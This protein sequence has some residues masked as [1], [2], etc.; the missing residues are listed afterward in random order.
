MNV[1]DC[2]YMSKE[3]LIE[4]MVSWGMLEDNREEEE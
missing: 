1:S 3:D 4:L 2:E